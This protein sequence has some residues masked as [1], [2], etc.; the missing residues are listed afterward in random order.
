MTM[1]GTIGG[2]LRHPVGWTGWLTG[3]V[4]R[5]VN[6]EPNRLAIGALGLRDGDR[7]L[8]LGCGP[9]HGVRMMASRLPHGT[10]DAVDQS[11][12]MLAQTR[13]R[14]RKAVASGRVRIHHGRFVPLPFDDAA[15]DKV[16]AVNV[17]YFW[18]DAEA[19]LREIRRVLRPRGVLSIYVTDRATMARW[20][21]ADPA[22][23]RRYD[24]EGLSAMLCAAGFNDEDVAVGSV[25]LS[26]GVTGLIASAR[27][28]LTS[29]SSPQAA[30]SEGLT[31]PRRSL[32]STAKFE[33]IN[34]NHNGEE[35]HGT[36]GQGHHEKQIEEDRAGAAQEPCREGGR[37]ECRGAGTNAQ[38]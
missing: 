6:G 36:R 26:W 13:S 21:F 30:A 35:D 8:E 18:H 33:N 12:E 37:E 19:V 10:V 28:T 38:A 11:L 3:H 2:Q 22:T 15:F 32:R 20:K 14:N 1:W 23:H 25:R 29:C 34:L 5:H 27:R 31:G 9:G 24:A 7:V 16:L 4:M 17:A